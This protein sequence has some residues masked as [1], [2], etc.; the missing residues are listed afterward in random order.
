MIP[1]AIYGETP[2]DKYTLSPHWQQWMRE[3]PELI[4]GWH[5]AQKPNIGIYPELLIYLDLY[6]IYNDGKPNNLASQHPDWIL[7]DDAG[8]NLFIP[9]GCNNGACPQF[10][11]DLTNPA[12]RQYQM[13][14]IQN[15]KDLGYQGVY[16]DDVNLA[17]SVGDGTGKMVAPSGVSREN[18]A[19]HV[20][21]FL[22][23][24]RSFFPTFTIAH[25][26]VWFADVPVE[27][28]NR[29]IVSCTYFNIERGYGDPNLTEIQKA[30]QLKFV[31]HVH[32]YGRNVIQLEYSQHANNA[33]PATGPL[34]LQD[35]ID[36]FKLGYSHGDL[37]VVYDLYPDAW[38]SI[39]DT[40]EV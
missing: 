12:F 16:L 38:L 19:R 10:A 18:W 17:L 31:D 34:T 1:L 11:G 33:D 40:N 23:G 3:R 27:Y 14:Q 39:M 15:L 9:W 30:R 29:Q 25:N 22:E 35:K 32:S 6:A 26:A 2:W 4:V 20:V 24:V 7:H 21:E 5:P 37:M 13:Q 8:N 36:W 28:L